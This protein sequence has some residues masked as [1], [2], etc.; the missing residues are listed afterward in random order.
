MH[1]HLDVIDRVSI[2]TDDAIFERMNVID[3]DYAVLLGI[4]VLA[5]LRSGIC[6]REIAHKNGD[7]TND[8][9]LSG[10]NGADFHTAAGLSVGED[11]ANAC[12]GR[13]DGVVLND[14]ASGI[15]EFDTHHHI[16]IEAIGLS[17]KRHGDLS[18]DTACIE[19][20]RNNGT[21]ITHATY[22]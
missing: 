16:T 20:G 3:G 6:G 18:I 17:G 5:I 11:M 19:I 9:S 22:A 13:C 21:Y 12:G 10:S 1:I 8:H 2:E 15:E 14:V 7:I 4:V